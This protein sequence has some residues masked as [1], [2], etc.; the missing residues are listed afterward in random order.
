MNI[1]KSFH[2]LVVC[3]PIIYVLMGSSK[4]DELYVAIIIWAFIHWSFL[5][6]ECILSYL[7]HK[8]DDPNYTLGQ[9]TTSTDLY[10]NGSD[11]PRILISCISLLLLVYIFKK[12]GYNPLI[13][14]SIVALSI[15]PSYVKTKSISCALTFTS[16][17]LGIYFLRDNKYLLPGL[18]ILLGSTLIV[19]H[20]DENS[21]IRGT[22]INKDGEV[23]E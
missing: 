6:N 12:A 23:Q 13:G 14:V 7:S 20:K 8:M 1:L 5:N 11:T 9:N 19:H 21:C 2:W 17:L 4:Y 22:Q 3:S 10:I 18:I 16:P 15:A